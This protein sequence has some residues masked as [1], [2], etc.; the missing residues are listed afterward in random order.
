MFLLNIS[1][2]NSITNTSFFCYLRCLEEKE[3]MQSSFHYD[4]YIFVRNVFPYL[5][6]Y[7]NRKIVAFLYLFFFLQRFFESA[8]TSLF[9]LDLIDILATGHKIEIQYTLFLT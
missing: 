6:L 3:I 1:F 9:P 4:L 5:L 2:Y 7:N 8:L